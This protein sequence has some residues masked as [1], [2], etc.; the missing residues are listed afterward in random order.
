MFN[1]DLDIVIDEITELAIEDW[2]EVFEGS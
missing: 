2:K 1:C